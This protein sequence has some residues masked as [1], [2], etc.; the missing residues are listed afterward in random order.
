ML[1]FS[2]TDIT[3]MSTP[4]F[5]T[6]DKRKADFEDGSDASCTTQFHSGNPGVSESDSDSDLS[7]IFNDPI[8]GT[9]RVSGLCMKIIDT[10]QFQRLRYL[11]QLGGGYFVYP[12]ATHNRFE[13]SIGTYHLAGKFARIL[14][15]KHPAHF[16]DDEIKCIEMAGLCHD[17]GHGPFSHVSDN[18][19]IPRVKPDS[20]WKHED[21]S[22]MMLEHL[23][24]ENSDVK[25]AF[26]ELDKD[27]SCLELVKDLILGGKE[28]NHVTTESVIEMRSTKP[29]LYEIVANSKT[30]IDV[31][32]W[33]YFARDCHMVGMKNNFDHDRYMEM[34]RINDVDGKPRIC[35]RDKNA[36]NLYDMFRTRET[37]H[38]RVYQ[39][40]VTRGVELMIVDALVKLDKTALIP[41]KMPVK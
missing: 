15:W 10:P 37:L 23:I 32:K 18:M 4:K 35:T 25:S 8:H 11:K 14:K 16:G 26:D 30:G 28:T 29:Y 3:I 20:K 41:G 1:I 40:P 22:V 7:K 38:R 6:E 9:I 33:D 27:W 39:H 2:I 13:H 34:A 21:A 36:S 31:D 5:K 19:F 17:L 12:G 24:K